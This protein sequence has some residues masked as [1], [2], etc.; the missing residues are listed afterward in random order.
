MRS[1][2]K[3][4]GPWRLLLYSSPFETTIGAMAL[5]TNPANAYSMS[6]PEVSE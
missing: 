2:V 3:A 1:M 6:L 4:N 5:R